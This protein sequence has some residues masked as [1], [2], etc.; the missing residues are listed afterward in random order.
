MTKFLFYAHFPSAA[1]L[2]SA[3]TSDYYTFGYT[4][5]LCLAYDWSGFLFAAT[6]GIYYALAVLK[7]EEHPDI[8]W[9][10]WKK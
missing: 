3:I 5:G 2:L 8:S 9:K 1:M 10:P 4:N 7:Y 6:G